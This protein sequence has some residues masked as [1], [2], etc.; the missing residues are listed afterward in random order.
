MKYSDLNDVLHRITIWV[1]LTSILFEATTTVK[2]NAAVSIL[3]TLLMVSL[4]SSRRKHRLCL[5][6]ESVRNLLQFT[7]ARNFKKLTNHLPPLSSN[8]LQDHDLYA[9]IFIRSELLGEILHLTERCVTFICTLRGGKKNMLLKREDLQNFET[10]LKNLT[11]N[12]K[13]QMLYYKNRRWKKWSKRIKRVAQKQLREIK[14]RFKRDVKI[15][16]KGRKRNRLN[17]PHRDQAEQK[18]I[19]DEYVCEIVD[20]MQYEST[21]SRNRKVPVCSSG[22]Y[23]KRNIQRTQYFIAQKYHTFKC[24]I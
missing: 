15:K 6:R 3:S 18:R 23:V 11:A 17:D 16:A 8:S 21:F 24:V 2:M 22:K 4:V 12:F 19:L 7:N 20:K 1:Q 9:R 10:H 5:E 14:R 13:N